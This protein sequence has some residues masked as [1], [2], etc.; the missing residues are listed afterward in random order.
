MSGFAQLVL[1]AL[2]STNQETGIFYEDSLWA[3]CRNMGM[4]ARTFWSY[5]NDAMTQGYISP[6][7][8]E[9]VCMRIDV[10][11]IKFEQD[12][13]KHMAEPRIVYR[14]SQITMTEDYAVIGGR[15]R[16]MSRPEL[17]LL[18]ALAASGTV[19]TPKELSHA[20]GN[21][22]LNEIDVDSMV[23]SL[24]LKTG[25][26]ETPYIMNVGG[27]GYVYRRP[28]DADFRGHP[29]GVKYNTLKLAP[30]EQRILKLIGEGVCT[31]NKEIA[32]SLCMS[33]KTAE[34]HVSHIMEK[35]G[36][37]KKAQLIVYARFRELLRNGS[38]HGFES[39]QDQVTGHDY[40]PPEPLTRREKEV[41]RVL[42]SGEAN[43]YRQIAKRMG[44]QVKT[45][46][47]HA[48]TLFKKL[49][50]HSRAEAILYGIEHG[51]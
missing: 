22:H 42:A 45:V 14:D 10:E 49:G 39:R 9:R 26:A 31:G 15:R 18:H 47:T 20:A 51:I 44:L 8:G 4:D 23:R 13:L 2:E 46:E 50:V 30:M 3:K 5:L 17:S 38:F 37:E 28:E 34:A 43:T 48:G 24:N 1:A 25:D 29:E 41:L 32:G 40:S 6:I 21:G 33:V 36:L 19:M 27:I 11:R 16:E 35:L 7:D 12:R